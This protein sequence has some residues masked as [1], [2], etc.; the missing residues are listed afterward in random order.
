MLRYGIMIFAAVLPGFA[1]AGAQ[2]A[3]RE[4]VSEMAS[5]VVERTARA[6]AEI[7]KKDKDAAA[8]Y[9]REALLNVQGIEAARP[10]SPQPLKV[11]MYTEMVQISV[12]QPVLE[13]RGSADRSGPVKGEGKPQVVSNVQGEAT[14]VFLN[15]TQ[16]KGHLESARKA[17]EG[18]DLAAADQAL[19]AVEKDVT[20]ASVVGDLPL[21]KARQNLAMALG[22]IRK[23]NYKDAAA[24]LREASSALS[25]YAKTQSRYAGEAAKLR[26]EIDA[27]AGSV[28]QNPGDA[29]NKIAKWWN[30]VDDWF[31]PLEPP[32]K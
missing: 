8:R 24:P 15:V 10:R 13:G 12:N 28:E 22:Q 30:D 27:L 7:G 2:P 29:E 6:R 26:A 21:L 3:D 23:R 31:T 16:A 9:V 25:D 14:R 11:T 19:A 1:Q 4:K 17:L 5:R 32:A 18:G 20:A